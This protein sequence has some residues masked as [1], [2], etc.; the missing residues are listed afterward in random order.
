MKLRQIQRQNNRD[1]CDENV[2]NW[3][4]V[5]LIVTLGFSV[6]HHLKIRQLRP[7]VVTAFFFGT[8]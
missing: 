7:K 1:N 8:T 3:L 4:S 6:H 5:A 2:I